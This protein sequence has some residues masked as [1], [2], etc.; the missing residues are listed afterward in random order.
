MVEFEV[1]PGT[2]KALEAIGVRNK[3]KEVVRK[4][5][6]MPEVV[7][8]WNEEKFKGEGKK[9]KK[10]T[11]DTQINIGLGTGKALEIFNKNII[12]FKEVPK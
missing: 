1:S 2:T 8:G 4:Y 3:A 11:G 10:A 6:D 9:G 5:P 7:K 12:K